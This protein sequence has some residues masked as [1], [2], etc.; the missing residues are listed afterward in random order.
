VFE[1]RA[2]AEGEGGLEFAIKCSDGPGRTV[3]DRYHPG[4]NVYFLEW[5]ADDC[6]GSLVLQRAA[7][8]ARVELQKVSLR[9]R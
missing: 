4:L 7:G 6:D 8:S 3:R 2:V 1:V 9:Q 5:R